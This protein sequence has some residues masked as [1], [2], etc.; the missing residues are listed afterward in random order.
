MVGIEHTEDQHAVLYYSKDLQ[1]PNQ[2]LKDKFNRPI[3]PKVPIKPAFIPTFKGDKNFNK[4]TAASIKIDFDLLKS[5]SATKR[6]GYSKSVK[7]S[8]YSK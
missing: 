4:N 8:G 2:E 6:S 7:R 5:L 3:I 1:D